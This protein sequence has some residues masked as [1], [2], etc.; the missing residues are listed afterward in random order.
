[1]DTGKSKPSRLSKRLHDTFSSERDPIFGVSRGFPRV[2]EL[3]LSEVRPNPDQPRKTIGDEALAELAGS[4]Q[5]HGL[6]QPIT[7][8]KAEEGYL[9]VAGER[10]FRAHQKLGRQTIFA[11][12]TDGNADEISLIENI[13]RENLHPLDEAEALARLIERHR[14]TQKELGKVIGK[15]QNTVSEL[16]QLTMLPESIKQEYRT[17]DTAV[18]K[19]VL[20]EIT[21]LADED[22]QRALW[23]QVKGGSTVR[24]VRHKK[25]G[26]G[27]RM[28]SVVEK[29]LATGRSFARQLA[30]TAGDAL[31]ANR[32]QHEELMALHAQIN[33]AINRLTEGRHEQ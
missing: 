12:I 2:V 3:N 23:D 4:I 17:S 29:M 10:R 18:S 28:P 21:R 14:Y 15:K 22:E 32:D 7:V 24:A 31:A 30:D 5:Q 19:S 16:L 9:L 20:I 1:M 11:I 8:K 26:D 6:L 33:D 25:E 27:N 13:Q